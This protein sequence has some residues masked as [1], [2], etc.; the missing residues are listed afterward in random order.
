[1][2]YRIVG[3]RTEYEEHPLG[4][5]C[6]T[7][8]FSWRMESSC[9]GAAQS[10]YCLRV[11]G[12]DG[13]ILW[14]TGRVESRESSGIRYRG[15]ALKA[16]S[17]YTLSVT[18][19][20]A[21][22][23]GQCGES[24]FETGLF[25]AGDAFA[26]AK[27]IGPA[28]HTL[29]GIAKPLYAVE[30]AFRV[31]PGG[32]EAGL[33]FG[34]EDPRL[35]DCRKNDY[36]IA[37]DNYIAYL[38][39]VS[40]L[41]AKLNIYRVGYA[42]GDRADRPFAQ[43]EIGP[44]LLHEGNRY[45][46]H[47]LRVEV[48]GNQASAYLDE[49]QVDGGEADMIL[50]TEMPMVR[51]IGRQLNPAGN[52]DVTTY[53]LLC[54][55]GFGVGAHTEARFRQYTVRNVR[56]PRAVI[57]S[58]GVGEQ[59]IFDPMPRED[60]CF[61]L[62][63]GEGPARFTADPSHT[64]LPLLR[65]EFAVGEGLAKARL[66]VT[67]RG[68]YQGELNGRALGNVSFTGMEDWLNPGAAQFDKHL[69]YQTY[70]VTGMLRAGKN[71]MG[72]ALAPG[73]WNESQT[74][75][76]LNYNYWGDRQ[77]LMCRLELTY[78]DGSVEAV[79][80]GTEG[81]QWFDRGPTLFAG[82]FY[83]EHRDERLAAAVKGFS[84]PGYDAAGWRTPQV[85]EP[86]VYEDNGIPGPLGKMWPAP[87][88]T[89]PVLVGQIGRPVRA[90]KTLTAQSMQEP[91]PGVYVYDMGQNMVGV[92]C[93]TL[94][95]RAGQ[96]IT[97]RYGEVCYP[98]LEEYAGKEGMILTENLRDGLSIDRWTLAGEGEETFCPRFTFH[99]YRFVEITGLEKPLEPGQ[100]T[101]IVLSSIGELAGG[102]ETSEPLVNKL[103]ENVTWSQRGNFVSIPTDCPQRN[104]RMGW[105]GD[106][107]VFARTALY[108]ADALRFYERYL[109]AM[110]DCQGEDG[111]Y[112]CIAPVGGGFGGLAWESAGIIVTYEVYR[113]YG[114]RKIIEENYEAM[115]A[116]L[117]CLTGQREWPGVLTEVQGGLGDWLASD[118]S[119]DGPLIW[120]AIFCYDAKILA[121]MAEAIGE[122]RDAREF[123][124]L[125]RQIK[126]IWNRTFVDPQT[127]KARGADGRENDTQ[128]AYALPLSYGVFDERNEARAYA[129]LSRKTREVGYTV[130]T[131]FVGT[132]ALNSALTAGGDGEAAYRLLM[133]TGYPSWLY[134][135]TQGAT[136]IWERWNSCTQE[137][138]F[139]GNNS[140]NSFNHYSLG[141]VAAWMYEDVLGIRRG[142]APG[143]QDF[144][145]HPVFG[146][147][148]YAKGHY[149][150]PY[151]RI[152]S[153]WERAGGRIVYTARVPANTTA[154]IVLPAAG[155]LEGGR[156][157]E[158]NPWLEKL[159]SCGG[160][161]EL[162]AKAGVYRFEAQEDG[163]TG[164]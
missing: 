72:F 139:G 149:D 136:T 164:A 160:N 25:P 24:W 40:S 137:A 95:G 94:R 77:S 107:Q 100:V 55:V 29:Q 105:A 46:F 132:P 159:G 157:V 87:N 64:S 91:K 135:V 35:L 102:F 82:L 161:V 59:G 62:R 7:P 21:D 69:Y 109:T 5:D 36:G 41:P 20:D 42:P 153:G 158:E 49:V 83:G 89:K 80:S 63:G 113:Q 86:T 65:R 18:V 51:T 98:A 110:R 130:T 114:D 120:N 56:K 3:I 13:E 151:G 99:G 19:W 162:R 2:D 143:F 93:I 141:A 140:M 58:E 12:E 27:W 44:E 47:T 88:R 154:R 142:E 17:R 30:A 38:I 73:W 45:G 155:L 54:Q 97:L 104:E 126:E 66:Y 111:R 67:A 71:A 68:I 133:Q 106:A 22:G 150:S 101:G 11:T 144:V 127:G 14:D 148:A 76:M 147:L 121:E 146:P 53:P 81:W 90:V 112:P 50:G 74:F 60:G 131:G 23:A 32:R 33:V 79:C 28:Q 26:G 138:G 8:R 52:N 9:P 15:A 43:V 57:F 37:G 10:A 78:R 145:L 84:C 48:V 16:A 31:M 129:H 163:R 123:A 128:C 124:A 34:A 61:V 152:E 115:K 4:I 116:Y 103:W 6:Q 134:S 156:P 1:M 75:T 85:I 118:L 108:N 119:T 96:E 117:N 70:D 92:P 39:D 122:T 125:H